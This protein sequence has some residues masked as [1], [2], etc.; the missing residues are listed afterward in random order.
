MPAFAGDQHRKGSD[1]MPDGKLNRTQRAGRF[2]HRMGTVHQV[3]SAAGALAMRGEI[4]QH[5]SYSAAAQI[6]G[7]RNHEGC[8]AGPSMYQEYAG[9]TASFGL[10]NIGLNFADAGRKTL[11]A[12]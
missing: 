12:R 7:E 6:V 5:G 3:G 1:R 9:G 4:E 2:A 11:R 8:F 10:E